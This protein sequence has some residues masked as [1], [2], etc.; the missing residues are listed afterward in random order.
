VAGEHLRV[1]E[2]AD[3]IL[4][5]Y[6]GRVPGYRFE[7]GP[8][9]V[10]EGAISL[11]IA[12]YAVIDGEE[13]LVYDTHVSVA[14]GRFVRAALEAAG[15]RRVTVLLS[16]WHLDHVAGS[17]AFADCELLATARTGELLF[18]NREEIETR[19]LEG[20]PAIAPLLLP[21][22]TFA[23]P[24]EFAVG[25][26]RLQLIPVDIHSDD[27]VVVWDPRARLLLAGDTVEDTVT[28]VDEPWGFEAHL[29]DL[30]R[31]LELGPA[32]VLPNH[33]DPAVISAGGYGPRL[34]SAT[35]DYIRFLR[36]CEAEPE[37]REMPLREVMAAAIE[38]GDVL[39]F[40]PYEEIHRE[41]IA[42][43]LAS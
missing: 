25:A 8:N 10:D 11:G 37:L 21:T 12:S 30:D 24:T 43:V 29:R 7:A 42:T 23:G 4:A 17:E 34:L 14:H 6:D 26:R 35:R 2:P 1:L 15:V 38:T 27:A 32:S 3:G 18:A 36:R 5:F 40:E 39:Y 41:N 33:G 13:A 20:P 28:F 19:A 22:R 9:W 16:D 31:L